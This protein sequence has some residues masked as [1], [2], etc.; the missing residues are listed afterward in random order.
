[1]PMK[2]KNVTKEERKKC[3]EIETLT[4]AK[5]AGKKRYLG[6]LRDLE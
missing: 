1:M 3:S 2:K 6:K 5:H 4:Q